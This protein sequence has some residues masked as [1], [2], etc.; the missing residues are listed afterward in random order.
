MR[1]V[2][3]CR[4]LAANGNA[5]NLRSEFSAPARQFSQWTCFCIL[6]RI[7]A[8]TAAGPGCPHKPD[9]GYHVSISSINTHLVRACRPV[10]RIDFLTR[11]WSVLETASVS[12][13]H[14]SELRADGHGSGIDPAFQI[15]SDYTYRQICLLWELDY[16]L[17][18][19]AF[20]DLCEF[21]LH[22]SVN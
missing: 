10:G 2:L 20:I 1:A 19:F 5:P 18:E 6:D 16:G 8:N 22:A 17:C 7:P 11:D 21:K 13:R 3:G 9:C 12:V 14:T 4:L 15:I